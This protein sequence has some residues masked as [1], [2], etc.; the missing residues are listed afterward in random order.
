MDFFP[1]KR[2]WMKNL[3][4]GL[5]AVSLLAM[6][7]GCCDTELNDRH[8]AGDHDDTLGYENKPM[9]PTPPAI[10]ASQAELA[11][12]YL[13]AGPGGRDYY[14]AASGPTDSTGGAGLFGRAKIVMNTGSGATAEAGKPKHPAK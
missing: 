10:T 2:N 9:Y 1:S 4:K 6:L 7:G 14:D 13:N 5:V 11:D 8:Y 12:Q 3:C